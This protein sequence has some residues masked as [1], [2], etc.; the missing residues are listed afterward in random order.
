LIGVLHPGR[1][2]PEKSSNLEQDL[3]EISSFFTNIGSNS[4]VVILLPCVKVIVI[5]VIEVRLCV[6][7]RVLRRASTKLSVPFP[8]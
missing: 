8:A 5:D 2:G 6:Q 1:L 7:W 4:P 3:L